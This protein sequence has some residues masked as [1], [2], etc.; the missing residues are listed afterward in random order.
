MKAVITV[1]GKDQ[2]GIVHKVTSLLV[3][4]KFNIIDIT[5]TILDG[6][7]TMIMIVDSQVGDHDFERVV[8]AYELLSKEMG[9]SI[10]VQNQELFDRM[11][12]V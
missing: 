3:E 6:N 1:I 9:L 8:K 5:Q 7:F 11:H 10:H 2:I 12:Q 4:Y